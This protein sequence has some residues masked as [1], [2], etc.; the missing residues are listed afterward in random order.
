MAKSHGQSCVVFWVV[1][2]HDVVR[3]Q[4]AHRYARKCLQLAEQAAEPDIKKTLIELSHIW[5]EAALK[6]ERHVYWTNAAQVEVQEAETS[7]LIAQG[8][9]EG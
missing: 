4:E 7:Q 6:E 5:I 8:L 9:H 2:Y 1:C 3:S